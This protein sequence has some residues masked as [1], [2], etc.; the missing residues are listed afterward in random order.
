[1]GHC[2]TSCLVNL[3]Y[4]SISTNCMLSRGGGGGD[5]ILLADCAAA[6]EE[7]EIVDSSA[8]SAADRV[9]ASFRSSFFSPS[10]PLAGSDS[11]GSDIFPWRCRLV[12]Q[13]SRQL[14]CRWILKWNNTTINCCYKYILCIFVYIRYPP[15]QRR[16]N[17]AVFLKCTSHSRLTHPHN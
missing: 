10:A 15:P 6:A 13:V 16:K 8:A 1:M 11:L 3:L 14:L 17:T 5:V 7:H 12:G 9:L 4:C 2:T